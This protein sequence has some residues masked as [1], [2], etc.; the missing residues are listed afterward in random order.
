MSSNDSKLSTSSC[1]PTTSREQ[2]ATWSARPFTELFAS[3][4]MSAFPAI[5]APP[6][7][8]SGS[9]SCGREAASTANLTAELESQQAKASSEN[10]AITMQDLIDTIVEESLKQP[11]AESNYLRASETMFQK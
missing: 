5:G 9:T 11:V 8:S 7:D 10:S 4:H 2:P 3:N 1:S 6:R